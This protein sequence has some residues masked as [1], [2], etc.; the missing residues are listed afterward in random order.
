MPAF[1][2]FIAKADAHAFVDR[3]KLVHSSVKLVSLGTLAARDRKRHSRVD[4]PALLSKG[5]G[6]CRCTC[7]RVLTPGL[8]PSAPK[9]WKSD[10]HVKS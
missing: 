6:H 8:T 9:Q 10:F 5:C 1:S 3:L 7:G 4:S 2:S